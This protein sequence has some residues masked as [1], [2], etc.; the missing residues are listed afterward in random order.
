MNALCGA[1]NFFT[2]P[3]PI[4]YT[5]YGFLLVINMVGIWQVQ[6]SCIQLFLH[7]Y[8]GS[9]FSIVLVIYLIRKYAYVLWIFLCKYICHTQRIVGFFILH[10]WTVFPGYILCLVDWMIGVFELLWDLHALD[11]IIKSFK[12]QSSFII[13]QTLAWYIRRGVQE[14]SFVQT[15]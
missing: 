11:L 13:A 8:I 14:L 7:G 10:I 2:E 3:P 4:P 1:I 15:F 12:V 5:C 9:L 6:H